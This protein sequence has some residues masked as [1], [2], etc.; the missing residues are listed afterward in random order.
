MVVETTGLPWLEQPAA[1]KAGIIDVG[2]CWSPG[3]GEPQ[4]GCYGEGIA[5]KRLMFDPGDHALLPAG[6][7]LAGLAM[8]EVAALKTAAFGLFPAELHPALHN[9]VSSAIHDAGLGPIIPAEGVT[10]VAGSV[11][12]MVARRGWTI[13]TRSFASSTF[14]GMVIRPITG[15]SVPAG[16]DVIWP[17]GRRSPAI[18]AFVRTVIEL[19]APA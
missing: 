13:V 3:S 4:S 9:A 16:L 11:P 2:F 12:L 7:P 8:L 18:D 5:A 19:A 1:L 14:P 17:E 6:H 15:F 10:S